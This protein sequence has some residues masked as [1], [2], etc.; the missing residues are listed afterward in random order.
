[1]PRRPHPNRKKNFVNLRGP[2]RIRFDPKE[3]ANHIR[4]LFAYIWEW[5]LTGVKPRRQPTPPRMRAFYN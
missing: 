5:I 1:M 3:V 4:D 2:V